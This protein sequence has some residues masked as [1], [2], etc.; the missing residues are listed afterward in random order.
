MA[1]AL[2]IGFL[3][4]A[5]VG[6]FI[7]RLLDVGSTILASRYLP[8]IALL[9]TEAA[10][11][12]P[13]WVFALRKYRCSLGRLGL[14]SFPLASGLRRVVQYLFLSFIINGTWALV[15]RAVG[16]EV[17]PDVLPVFGGGPLGLLVALVAASLVAPV[18]EELFFRGFLFAGLRDR[19]GFRWATLLSAAFFA[20]AH[21]T[22]GALV[23]V[24]FLGVFFC[25]L[26]AQT[27]S[28]WPSIFMHGAMNS[29]AIVAS[30]ISSQLT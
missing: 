27:G 4:I 11:I 14:R 15:A 3:A 29:L 13:V 21:F 16:F 25:L 22:P 28:L 30:F 8:G 7:A 12:I 1:G 18:V 10:F 24:F 2:L 9:L 6:S 26:Y 5:V 17:Q 23:P 19:F 20:M